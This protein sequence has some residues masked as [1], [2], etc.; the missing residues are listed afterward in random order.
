MAGANSGSVGRGKS[1]VVRTPRREGTSPR[2]DSP[3]PGAT[4]GFVV[5][6]VQRSRLDAAVIPIR[7]A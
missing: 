4:Q 6:D 1:F 3:L 5:D 2:K 7:Q